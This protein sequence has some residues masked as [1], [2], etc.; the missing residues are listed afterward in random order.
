MRV[1]AAGPIVMRS[2]V[3]EYVARNVLHPD[4]P[5]TTPF[6]KA[7]VSTVPTMGL[8]TAWRPLLKPVT[9]HGPP[10]GVTAASFSNAST[11]PEAAVRLRRLPAIA[12]ERVPVKAAWNA[13]SSDMAG[14]GQAIIVPARTPTVSRFP[15]SV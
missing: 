15:L 10:S 7:T 12:Y 2:P 14:S 1:L 9:S 5:L 3:V 4:W 11:A 6:S 8:T 13:R